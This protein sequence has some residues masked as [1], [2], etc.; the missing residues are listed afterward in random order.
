MKKYLTAT[1]MRNPLHVTIRL[2]R[3][4]KKLLIKKI[5]ALFIC[6]ISQFAEAQNV[7][8]GTKNPQNKLHVAGGLRIDSLAAKKDSGLILHN[9]SGD[10]YSLSLTGKKSD[11]LRGD[12][13]F[14]ASAAATDA[15]L[16]GGNAGTD[17]NMNFIGTTDNTPLRIRV[18]GGWFGSLGPNVSLGRASYGVMAFWDSTMYGTVADNVA[19]GNFALSRNASGNYNVAVGSYS[20][21]DVFGHNNTAIGFQAQRGQQSRDYIQNAS[22]N[23]AVGAHALEL[24]SFA[25][26][27]TAV[28]LESM[29]S[30]GF[31]HWNTAV[32]Y[33]SL[34]SLGSEVEPQLTG[35]NVA[36]GGWP[37]FRM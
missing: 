31:S 19:I 24:N 5:A 3:K 22:G 32:G 27:N 26:Y 2:S 21:Q 9:K 29:A 30:N 28:G 17:S 14:A 35:Y 33:R 6:T 10:V 8:I 15:W 11:V 18:N 12:G 4:T 25:D 34:Y 16:L 20:L 37:C 13:T 7:G 23:T 1:L 36:I